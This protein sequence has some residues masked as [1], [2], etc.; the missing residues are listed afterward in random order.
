MIVCAML[1][2]KNGSFTGD[3][4]RVEPWLNMVGF[5]WDD[6]VMDWVRPCKHRQ[7]KTALG[8]AVVCRLSF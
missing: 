2:N 7:N 3:L 1:P 5:G 6:V 4:A 8:G